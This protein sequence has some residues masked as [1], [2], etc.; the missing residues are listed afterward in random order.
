VNAS[1]FCYWLSGVLAAHPQSEEGTYLTPPVVDAVR[2][3][4]ASVLVREQLSPHPLAR[5]PFQ[6]PNSRA[7]V[8]DFY[9]KQQQAQQGLM[10]AQIRELNQNAPMPPGFGNIPAP[11]YLS[12]TGDAR[13]LDALMI[14][15]GYQPKE[16]E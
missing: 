3:Q 8:A 4:L 13:A 15:R 16:Q 2:K 11:E 6:S 9:E 7:Y 10:A 14:E 1:D 12:G 5:P